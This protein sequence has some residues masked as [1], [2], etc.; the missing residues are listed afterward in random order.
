MAKS[1]KYVVNKLA[2]VGVG[3]IGGSIGLGLR[4]KNF[5]R[6]IVGIGRNPDRLKLAVKMGAI[7]SWS[8]S[9]KDAADAD[10]VILCTP[11]MKISKFARAIARNAK[12]P[13]IFTD[14]GSVKSYVV[15]NT[16]KA[17]KGLKVKHVFVG[18]HPMAGSE[19]TG[20]E[21]A[22]ARLFENAAV[23]I[24]PTKNTPRAGAAKVTGM[25]KLLKG[26]IVKLDPKNHDLACAYVSHLPHMAAYTLVRSLK[27]ASTGGL[28]NILYSLCAGG[29][30]DTTDSDAEL[31]SEI[32]HTNSDEVTRSA[33]N[34]Q[35][36][37]QQL[38]TQ[39]SK[40]NRGKIAG[41]IKEVAS[42]RRKIPRIG[43]G[44]L[45]AAY[46]LVVNVPDSPGQIAK[47]AVPLSRK[48]VNI[49]DIEVLHVREGEEGNIRLGFKTEK[50]RNE[51]ARYLRRSKFAVVVR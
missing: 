43:R 29:F 27:S 35:K 2:I 47:I 42:L 13:I 9:P 50:E 37:F 16:E 45:K 20:V 3:L 49:A 28:R 51:A 22:T 36:L 32:F 23:I 30:R 11:V 21:Y 40:G 33:K 38:T 7:D 4:K 25:W 5:A 31:W 44:L 34:F 39:V 15:Q 8:L 48:G 12:K 24:T 19:Q 18:A 26:K 17:L 41:Q 46:E 14:V 6:E 10:M 1:K